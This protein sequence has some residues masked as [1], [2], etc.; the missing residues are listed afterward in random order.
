MRISIL[1]SAGL[2]AASSVFAAS[3]A[4]SIDERV[5]ELI[6]KMTLE[7]KVGQ[8]NQL[9]GYGYTPDM[10]GRVKAGQVGSLL[11]VVDPV[12][13]NK[14]Q[15]DAVENSRLGI[16]LIFA[17][18][19]IHGF[20]TMM[21]IPLGQAATWNTTV[22]EQGARVAAREATASGVRWTFSPMVDI[23][24]DSRW[25]RI[26]EGYGEDPVLTSAM[27]VATVRGYQG[28]D[29]SSPDAMA[30]CMK[31]FACYG[32]SEGGRDYNTTWI[33]RSLLHD[34]YL[35]PF[36]ACAKAG[37]A[38]A[39][40]SFNDINGIPSS[41]NKYLLQDV[42]RNQW[43]WPGV[44]VSDWNSIGEMVN[45][46]FSANS[47]QAAAQGATAG[48]DIDMEANAYSRNLAQ[49]VK[50]GVV[51]MEQLDRLV[52]NVLRLK[53]ELGLFDNPYT[54]ISATSPFYAADALA[55]AQKAAEE[56]AI[57]LSN[58]GV[59]P[60]KSGQ[61]IFVTGPMADAQ[62]D[63]NGTWSYDM[64]KSHTVTPLSALRE[65]Y[66]NKL[67]YVAG[68]DYSRDRSKA[69]FKKALKEAKKA[70]VIIYFA[71][72]E[73]VLSG[74]AHCRADVTLPGAQRDYLEELKKVGKP[75]V[76]IV[77][78]GRPNALAREA[79]LSDALV[80]FYHP[81]TMGGPA[82]ANVL[83]GTVNPGGKLPTSMPRMSGQTPLYYNCKN[84][85]RPT[86]EPQYI[87]SIPREA[88]QTSTGCTTF[89]LD[90]GIKPLY[91]FGY[92]LSYTTFDYGVPTLSS[93]EI[94]ADGEVT[95]T[96]TVTNT[97]KVSGSEVAQLYVRDP[98]AS[99]VQPVKEL[100]GFEKL[101]LQPGESRKVSF[102]LPARALAFHNE[103]GKPVIES[104]E[105]QVWVDG[106][107]DTKKKPVVFNIR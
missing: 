18:D 99:I 10:A 9:S 90:A 54:E 101:Y 15:H 83:D 30:A 31:H 13:C 95:V 79:E 8:L 73:A 106:S 11:N 32:A 59:L 45:H 44:V 25:G 85:G 37:A 48:V 104:G 64:E 102:K 46:G 3:P 51:P 77:M 107:S 70:D 76:T 14:L 1:L 82:I 84:T 41:G 87:D 74:E 100:K 72:E 53:F 2:I 92:G 86:K 56:S 27:G 55:C 61:K 88:G 19:V 71:G 17:R 93:T 89:Y 49:L 16:P 97:G 94:G 91:P 6:G 80:L 34:I 96:C 98:V 7:E 24:R 28:D 65:R 62:H 66:G 39:M 38:T 75:I 60:L 81:G 69:Q 67:S 36:E 35:P 21:P 50:D 40:C 29:L 42:L 4:K 33:P 23:A 12:V 5:G 105:I 57:L 52:A 20:K 43:Q 26:A 22:V 78:T 63:Q 58:N 47:R 103:D 68:L